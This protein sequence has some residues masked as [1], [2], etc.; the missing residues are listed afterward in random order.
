MSKD[1]LLG[2]LNPQQAEAVQYFGNPLLVLAGAGSGKTKVITHKYAHLVKTKKFQPQ[3]I[4]TVTF[5]NKAADEMKNRITSL[6]GKDLNS[7][8]IGTFHSQCN[9]I[10][11]R[12]INALEYGRNFM[13]YDEDDQCSLIRHILR[14]FKIYEAMYKGVASRIS[15]FKSSLTS[16][17]DLLSTSDGFGFDEKLIKIYVRYQDELKKCNA[18]D[19]DDLI[20]LTVK[21]FEQN[22]KILEQYR[23]IFNY[24]L[25][26]EF[27]DTNYAQY[28]LLKLLCSKNNICVVGDDDQSIY[29]FRGADINNILNFEKDF[30]KAKV[31]KL[32][33]NYRSTQN[34]LDAASTVIAGNPMR[35]HKKLWTEKGEGEKVHHCWLS[36]EEEEAK[37]IAGIIK[38]LYLEGKYNYSDFAALYRVNFQSR[39]IEDAL[40]HELIPY[41]VRGGV[42]FYQ[43]KEVKD[44]LSYLRLVI[45]PDDN[46]SLRRAIN[47]PPRGIGAATIS[48]IENE[49]S[50]KS[51][52]LFAAIK[53]ILKNG[54]IAQS[55]KEKLSGFI[56]IID[57]ISSASYSSADEI[58]KDIIEKTDYISSIEE[59][60]AQ[61][62]HELIASA[63]GRDIN[64]FAD[65]AALF[66][67]ADENGA[68]N[69]VSLMTMH[70]TKGLEFPVV[71]VVGLEDGVVPYFKALNNEEELSEERRLFYV[72][73]TRAKDLLWLTGSKKRRLYTKIQ[74]QERSRFLGDIPPSCCKWIEKAEPQ[75]AALKLPKRVVSVKPALLYVVGSRVKHPKWGIGVVRDCYGEAGEQK[76]MVN[77]PMVG[78]KR[79]ALRFANLEKI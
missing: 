57:A 40:R 24:V 73:I 79:L 39:A 18:L 51:L 12:D 11:R 9:R 22:P 52:S 2:G 48:K 44:V 13:I 76:V 60:R 37:H 53:A 62:V 38:E 3:S 33:Q 28:K 31:V 4:L 17:K 15:S 47:C 58:L 59:E 35:R 77:F 55:A 20:L 42:S 75:R 49:A 7:S 43:R 63:E 8:W 10:L 5:T 34:I 23:K 32:E 70:G 61:N 30:P 16:P 41:R 27:Q 46:V 67:S 29:K 19:F 69:T 1:N 65:S 56:K 74:D 26:D 45:N 72:S 14:D 64:D 66:A 36:S 21:L 71:F 68:E 50:R 6:I 78:L 54:G 25:V